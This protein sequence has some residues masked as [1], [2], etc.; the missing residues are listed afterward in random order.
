MQLRPSLA[1]WR[2]APTGR[3][4]GNDPCGPNRSC[5]AGGGV[6]LDRDPCVGTISFAHAGRVVT[7]RSYITRDTN[8]QACDDLAEQ[9][10]NGCPSI[11]EAAR[12]MRITQI[13]ADQH[14]QAIK[15]ALGVEQCK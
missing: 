10:A 13:R 9:M 15:S 8:R 11:S 12:R 7:R 5:P 6:T 3:G 4:L 1:G 14:W 2:V